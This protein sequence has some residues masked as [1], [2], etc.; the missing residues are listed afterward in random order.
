MT[1]RQP[2]STGWRMAVWAWP[3]LALVLA[4]CVDGTSRLSYLPPPDPPPI[5][6]RKPP[7]SPA[8]TVQMIEPPIQANLSPRPGAVAKVIS[9]RRGA[10]EPFVY[11]VQPGDTVYGVSRKLGVPLREVMDANALK[12]PYTLSVSQ[13]LRIANP[14]RHVI[15]RGETMYGISRGYGVE[16]T[17]LVRLN[18]IAPPYTISPGASL[19]LPAAAL[20]G[21]APRAT[22][23]A[24]KPKTTRIANTARK[25]DPPAKTAPGAVQKASVRVVAKPARLAVIPRP[26]PRAG[27]KFQ[28]PAKGKLLATFGPKQGG[29]HNDGINIAAP[30]GAPVRAAE[31]G[32]VIYSGNELRGF[33]N[34][35]L[36][37]HAGGW[38]TA[39]AHTEGIRVA[40]GQKVKRGQTIAKI[41][42]SGNVSRP[43]LHFEIRKGSRAVDP[44]RYLN[45]K[46]A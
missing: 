30:R 46:T 29:L 26:P 17:E 9:V 5:P 23:A 43:Q 3:L 8:V 45:G 25:L 33:G 13:Q 6:Q 44:R 15:A 4:S 41:G 19:V 37:K 31:N 28:W 20:R 32:V 39:Y 18:R 36:I 12:P 40:R 35:I 16:M 2:G 42:S 21:P 22:P 10:A 1:V 38:V 24:S 27:S 34:L 14:R 11:V 7:L